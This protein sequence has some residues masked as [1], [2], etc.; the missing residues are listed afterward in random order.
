MALIQWNPEFYNFLFLPAILVFSWL[1][2][3]FVYN[4]HFHPLAHIPGPFF[5]RRSPWPSAM[6]AWKGDRHLWLEKCFNKHG[7]V[8]RVA[9]NT[10]LFR[11][12]AAYRD[13]YGSRANVRRADFYDGLRRSDNETS[14]L[15]Y[16]DNAMHARSRRMLDLA[17]TSSSLRSSA[18]FMQQHINRWHELLTADSGDDWTQPLNLTD[19]LNYLVLDI[20][21][22]VC[23][24]SSLNVMEP[25]DSPLKAVPRAVVNTATLFNAVARSPLLGLISYLRSRGLSRVFK[26]IRPAQVVLFDEFVGKSIAQR[27]EREKEAERWGEP[28][29]DMFHFI[30]N[31][32][33]D[34]TGSAAFRDGNLTAECRLLVAAGSDSTSVTLSGLFFYLSHYGEALGKLRQEITSTFVSPEDIFPGPGLSSCKYLKAAIDEAMRMTPAGLSELPRQVLPEG[35]HINGEYFPENTVVGTAAWCDGYNEEIYGDAAIYRPERWLVDDGNSAQ[36]VARIKANFHPFS[37]GP[38]NCV[39]MNFAL[40]ELM[41]VVAKT[42][43]RFEFRLAPEW[44]RG[45]GLRHR[46]AYGGRDVPH[47]QLRDAFITVRD[48]PLLQFRRRA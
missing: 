26:A 21:C 19:R 1:I 46:R 47:F 30:Y 12:P 7:N 8:L 31:A 9:P 2:L 43:H 24:G 14:T 37:I 11:N 28:R 10:V 36:D 23:F 34:R 6:H 38:H 3:Q 25:G 32:R 39:G 27:V 22:D 42:V 20:L 40:Q 45:E 18:D 44:E 48:G 16:T 41:L 5:G 33:D 29:K 4:A 35:A 17:F 13:I 15:T